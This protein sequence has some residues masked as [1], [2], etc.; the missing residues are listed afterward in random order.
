MFDFM[1]DSMTEPMIKQYSEV[2]AR[3]GGN[4]GNSKSYVPH[5]PYTVSDGSI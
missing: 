2:Y 4:N 5:A 1:Q 3:H